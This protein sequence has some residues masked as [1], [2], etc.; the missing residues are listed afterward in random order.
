MLIWKLN[1][2]VSSAK[3]IEGETLTHQ[4][5]LLL[6]TKS[7]TGACTQVTNIRSCAQMEQCSTKYVTDVLDSSFIRFTDFFHC[8]RL[9]EFVT[10]STT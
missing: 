10:G 9:F 5:F 2:K 3:M 4:T 1:V 8:I 6:F 7:G